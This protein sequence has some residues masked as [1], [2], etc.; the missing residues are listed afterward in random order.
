MGEGTEVINIGKHIVSCGSATDADFPSMF[1]GR[2]ARVFY[3]DP[4]WSDGNLNYWATLCK[5]QAGN[6]VMAIKYNDLLEIVKRVIKD[7]V[8][9]YIFL[10]IGIK[11]QEK[12]EQ[13][14]NSFLFNVKP[15]ET[16]YRSGS[17]MLPNITFSAT[18]ASHYKPFSEKLTG[19]S[20]Y[21]ITRLCVAECG[22]PDGLV[23][24]PFCGM[25]YTAQAAIDCGMSFIGNELNRTR[26][27]KTI[28]RLKTD[29]N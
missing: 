21:P 17:K 12:V 13:L 27:E 10:E 3:S 2:K 18:T 11:A 19:M 26:L 4:P 8:D 24:D 15:H 7:H 20:G 5:K 9:G 25:G 14:L 6:E 22:C 23:V 29:A 28:K 16:L 1:K